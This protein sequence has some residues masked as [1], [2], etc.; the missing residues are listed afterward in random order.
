VG[1]LKLATAVENLQF[2][3]VRIHQ[4]LHAGTDDGRKLLRLCSYHRQLACG[5]LLGDRDAAEFELELFKSA[6]CYLW[7]LDRP[8]GEVDPY[9]LCRSRAAPLIDAL[10]AGR[11]DLAQRIALL[12]QSP[13]NPRMEPEE[14]FRWFAVLGAVAIPGALQPDLLDAFEATLE[15]KASVRYDLAA[16]ILARDEKALAR[17]LESLAA[18]WPDEVKVRKGGLD[19]P[20]FPITEAH[21]CVEGVAVARLASSLGLRT[22]RHVR[23]MPDAV[24][25]PAQASFPESYG[26]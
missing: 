23:F 6:R 11:P 3:V 13:F 25:G 17:A 2:E 19:G 16:A 12:M 7:L 18:E 20:Y 15:G 4:E 22:P 21:V 24:L 9:Y 1:L 26:P 5:Y 14:G 8:P 10:A